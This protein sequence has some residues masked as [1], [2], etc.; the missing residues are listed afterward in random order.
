MPRSSSSGAGSP[1]AASRTTS[2]RRGWR[3]V[4]LLEKGELTSGSTCHAAGL[5]TQFN[6]SPTMMRF[7]RYSVEL[8]R[9][10][11][12]FDSVGSLRIASSPES[13]A[14]AR[15]R[16]QPRPRDRARRRG[17]RRRT[18]SFGCCPRPRASRSTGRSGSRATA[19]SI[20]TSRRTRS[21][22]PPGSSACGSRP[23][24]ASP[25]SELGP[26]PRGDRRRHR[27]RADR[28]GAGRERLRDLGAAGGGDGGGV[29]ALGAGRPPAHRSRRGRRARAAARDAVLPGPRQSRLRQVRGRRD[30]LRRLRAEPGRALDG[31]GALGSRRR[32]GSDRTTSASRSSWT[33]PCG[34]SPSCATR[35]S[36]R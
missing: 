12:V 35:A 13:L 20:R 33:A 18:R 22:T 25:G 5:V 6:P 9:E 24:V 16:R 23:D 19:R 31:R 29:H 36:S 15:A 17:A 11:G 32:A 21:R 1:G 7:R 8:Y 2:R 30:P 26:S 27:R 34:A 14:G 28:D 3:D 10:L 4:L